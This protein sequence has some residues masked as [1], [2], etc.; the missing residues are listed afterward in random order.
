MPTW[1][2]GRTGRRLWAWSV[3]AV[4]ASLVPWVL[5]ATTDGGGSEPPLPLMLVAVSLGGVSARDLIALDVFVIGLLPLLTGVAAGTRSRV[6]V[7]AACGICG[8]LGLLHLVHFLAELP[9]TRLPA[10]ADLVVGSQPDFYLGTRP[11]GG[12]WA[13]APIAYAVSAIALLVATCWEGRGA[14]QDV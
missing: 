2:N 5:L 11:Y 6:L 9:I 7:G 13:L 4:S 8:V 14:G 3:V 1:K 12:F 10:D